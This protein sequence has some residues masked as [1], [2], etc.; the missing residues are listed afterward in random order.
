MNLNKENTN[1]IIK[2]VVV[3]IVL[4]VIL[5]NL[6][7]VWNIFKIFLNI[8]SPFLWGLAIAFILNIFMTFYE[9]TLFNLGKRKKNKTP[10]KRS[11]PALRARRGI[12]KNTRSV[13]SDNIT[14]KKEI[15]KDSSG[16]PFITDGQK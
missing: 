10:P 11:D 1:Q 9:N 13:I 14:S 6:G 2:I 8:I 7:P 3:A 12:K 5:L 4:L 16:F 15:P